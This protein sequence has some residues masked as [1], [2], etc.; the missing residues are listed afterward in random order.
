[1]AYDQILNLNQWDQFKTAWFLLQLSIYTYLY[2][3][4]TFTDDLQCYLLSSFVNLYFSFLWQSFSGLY[5]KRR[6][7]DV[8]VLD[9]HE[10]KSD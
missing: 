7:D 2:G 1:M 5:I 10:K 8:L 3:A 6:F 4:V 9:K